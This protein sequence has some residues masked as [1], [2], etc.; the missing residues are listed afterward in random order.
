MKALPLV[1]PENLAAIRIVR[2]DD[3]R[4]TAGS[5]TQLPRTSHF[6][7]C[8]TG[9]NDKTVKVRCEGTQYFVFREDVDKLSN[10]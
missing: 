10:N 3:G 5:I 4:E 9:F 6:E 8:G 2:G 7:P 1:T